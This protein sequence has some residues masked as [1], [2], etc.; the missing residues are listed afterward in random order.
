M[1]KVELFYVHDP[2]CSW[3]FGFTPTYKKLMDQLPENIILKRLVGGLAPDSDEPMPDTTREMVQQNW[4]RIEQKIPGTKFNF[5]FWENCE[6]RRSTYP[7]CRAVIAARMQ[8][9][10][11]DLAMTQAIQQAYYVKAL[12]PSDDDVLMACAKE[13]GLDIKQFETDYFSAE[14]RHA[15]Y[16]EIRFCR[17]IGGNSFPSIIIFKDNRYFDVAIDYNQPEIMLEFIQGLSL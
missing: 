7:S 14:V 15:L 11:F 4:H 12:N 16:D 13:A 6:P 9:E 2:M 8:D 5:A 10:A 3:C 17:S 1:S